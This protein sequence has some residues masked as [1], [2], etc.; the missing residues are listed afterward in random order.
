MQMPFPDL[1]ES[2]GAKDPLSE[3]I[4]V[5]QTRSKPKAN[6]PWLLPLLIGGIAVVSVMVLAAAGVLIYLLMSGG[7]G[8]TGGQSADTKNP[9]SLT[10]KENVGEASVNNSPSRSIAAE[11]TDEEMEK[12]AKQFAV[13]M[14]SRNP[15]EVARYFDNRVFHERVTEGLPLS[16]ADEKNFRDTAMS[17]P[18][19]PMAMLSRVNGFEYE[20]LRVI[21]RQNERRAILRMSSDPGGIN[22]HEL[23]FGR[24]ALG[25]V[26]CIDLFVL[27]TSE[28]L[29]ETVKHGALMILSQRDT[30]I[31]GKLKGQ[32]RKMIELKNNMEKINELALIN[33]KGALTMMETLSPELQKSRTHMILK[34]LLTSRTDPIIYEKTAREFKTLF[35][36]DPVLDLTSINY[37]A[38]TGKFDECRAAIDRLDKYLGGDPYLDTL[39]DSLPRSG[40]VGF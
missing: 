31:L 8:D 23:I 26:V 34:L 25:D 20:F 30:S 36:N 17:E 9:E 12:V 2:Y 7:Q 33:P 18:P 4:P 39:R 3:P 24:N 29:S 14:T 6:K 21:E 32:D 22:Y 35:P 19:A 1:P 37:L 15:N 10:I 5:R 11:I 38:T 28:L 16:K 13:A 40:P 27:S